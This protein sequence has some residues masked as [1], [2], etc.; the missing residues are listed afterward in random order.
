MCAICGIYDCQDYLQLWGDDSFL[1]LYPMTYPPTNR[2]SP[3]MTSRIEERPTGHIRL[4][5]KLRSAEAQ[6]ACASLV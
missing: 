5:F 1:I 4:G 2:S 3:I 6:D